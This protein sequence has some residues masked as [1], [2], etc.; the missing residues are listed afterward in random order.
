MESRFHLGSLVSDSPPWGVARA[1][2]VP[3]P[4]HIPAAT[5]W[6]AAL[7]GSLVTQVCGFNPPAEM[8]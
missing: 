7:C 3:T 5:P 1:C 4:T 2:G 6:A 8:N